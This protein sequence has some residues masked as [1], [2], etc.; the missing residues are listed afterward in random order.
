[1]YPS[2]KSVRYTLNVRLVG[3]SEVWNFGEERS[4]SRESNS[5]FSVVQTLSCKSNIVFIRAATRPNEP[6]EFILIEN[7]PLCFISH[8]K[9]VY[10][11]MNTTILYNFDRFHFVVL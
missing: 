3:R 1:L 9:T 4:F 6:D 10:Y 11:V 8:N 5:S 7:I 2:A